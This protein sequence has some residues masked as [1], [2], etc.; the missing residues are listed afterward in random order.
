[1]SI[2][3]IQADIEGKVNVLGGYSIGHSKQ[4]VYLYNCPI[5]NGF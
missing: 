2:W 3:F 4:K 5:L 1:M